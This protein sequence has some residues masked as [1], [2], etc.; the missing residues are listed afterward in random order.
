MIRLGLLIFFSLLFSACS[1]SNV[2]LEIRE[3]LPDNPELGSVQNDAGAYEG[4]QIRWG[5][6]IISV[7]NNESDT[8]IVVLAKDLGR[9]GR[10]RYVDESIGRFIVRADEFL[11]PDIYEQDREIT[12][13]GPIEGKVDRKIGEKPYI[14]PLVKSDRLYLWPEYR[15]GSAY[16]SGYY[17]YYPYYYPYDFGFHYGHRH[18]YW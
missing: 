10:P 14:Y 3:G 16:P 8:W 2:P 5:G 15:S 6:T 12:V 1:Y 17:P 4:E 18:H 13:Y 7:E 11:D 9:N